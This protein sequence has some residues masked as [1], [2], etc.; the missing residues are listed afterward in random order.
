V[1]R[2]AQDDKGDEQSRFLVVALLGMTIKMTINKMGAM[3][4][5]QKA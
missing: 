2:W 1:F 5:E 3:D 4:L